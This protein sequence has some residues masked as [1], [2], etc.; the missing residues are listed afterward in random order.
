M[1]VKLN[2]SAFEHAKRLI[3]EEKVEIDERDAW[4]EHQPSTE[5]EN[6]FIH[7]HGYE[8]YAKWHLGIDEETDQTKKDI[9]FPSP[10]WDDRCT[11]VVPRRM[12]TAES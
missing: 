9:S 6:K 7:R 5:E 4:S 3:S 11:E 12:I 2:E 1:A 8:E 10:A